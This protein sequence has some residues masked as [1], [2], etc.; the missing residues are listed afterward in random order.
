MLRNALE[1]T[2]MIK[3][4]MAM[5]IASTPKC[6]CSDAPSENAHHHASTQPLTSQDLEQLILKLIDAKS[7]P[8]K[9]SEGPEPDTHAEAARASKSE[10]NTMVSTEIIQT[11]ITAPIIP[12]L[13]MAPT[14]MAH[15]GPPLFQP[16]S[17]TPPDSPRLLPVI[18][19]QAMEM[20]NAMARKK[21]VPTTLS[22]YFSSSDTL[23]ENPP[24][25]PQ[26]SIVEYLEQLISKLIEAKLPIS[27]GKPVGPGD[28]KPEDVA[29]EAARLDFKTVD[30][31]YVPKWR[32]SPSP[33]TSYAHSVGT[34]RHTR[35]RSWNP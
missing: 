29:D 21:M 33:L 17:T 7:K 9:S 11:G 14:E 4:I 15:H 8:P 35:M 31:L 20:I 5:Q 12:T 25:T 16:E 26:V 22:S 30:E 34:G 32:A 27:A 3:A 19:D 28:N 10:H 24:P 2:D 6:A 13:T 1:F 18:D 23:L